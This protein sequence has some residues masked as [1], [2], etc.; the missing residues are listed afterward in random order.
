MNKIFQFILRPSTS[1]DGSFEQTEAY[2]VQPQIFGRWYFVAAAILK[3]MFHVV[4]A[5]EVVL[6]H[7]I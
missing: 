5:C 4:Q 3:V 6:V 7:P 2:L 1:R